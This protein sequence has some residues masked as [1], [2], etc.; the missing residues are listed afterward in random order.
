MPVRSGGRTPQLSSSR[1]ISGRRSRAWAPCSTSGRQARSSPRRARAALPRLVAVSI[2]S[3]V[4]TTISTRGHAAAAQEL[5]DLRLLVVP[6]QQEERAHLVPS[7]LPFDLLDA[8]HLGAQGHPGPGALVLAGD[9]HLVTDGVR[10]VALEQQAAA[11]DVQGRVVG[12]LWLEFG[13]LHRLDL[14]RELLTRDVESD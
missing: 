10:P 4:M 3:T 1:S 11:A 14:D 5:S 6:F 9:D 13:L 8:H 2:P 7:G 12:V